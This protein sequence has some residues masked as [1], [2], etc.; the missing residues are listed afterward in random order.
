MVEHSG[1]VDQA[2]KLVITVYLGDKRIA[3]DQ[4]ILPAIQGKPRPETD[5]PPQP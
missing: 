4:M 5:K 1:E 2:H 3:I